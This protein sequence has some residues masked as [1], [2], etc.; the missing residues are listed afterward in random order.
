M[1]AQLA[2]SWHG[3]CLLRLQ[4]CPIGSHTAETATQS[5][6]FELPR[7]VQP[8]D[9]FHYTVIVSATMCAAV[10]NQLP[11][12]RSLLGLRAAKRDYSTFA[13]VTGRVIGFV[14]VRSRQLAG[15]T[16]ERTR[17]FV[18]SIPTPDSVVGLQYTL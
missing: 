11:V 13:D 14:F 5:F 16:A 12:D 9:L 15:G 6:P 4:R 1:F 2:K 7:T 3:V 8:Y 17:V 10:Q 18:G